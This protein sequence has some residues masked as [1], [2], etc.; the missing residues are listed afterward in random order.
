MAGI[1]IPLLFPKALFVDPP[2]VRRLRT[3]YEA[4]RRVR[5]D[6]RYSIVGQTIEYFSYPE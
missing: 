1:R 6:V 2:V 3:V 4:S 5:F